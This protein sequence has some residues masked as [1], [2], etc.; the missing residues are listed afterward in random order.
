MLLS[1]L[2]Q[3]DAAKSPSEVVAVA[4]DYLAS[5]TPEELARLPVQCR[6]GRV[7]D[8]QDIDQLLHVNLV[9]EYGRNRLSGE[10]LAALQRLT[11]FIVRA[12][13]RIAQIRGKEEVPPGQDEE[14]PS[15]KRS[16]AEREH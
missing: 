14:P 16:A 10:A 15:G 11:S 13:V 2:Q 6:P 4:R 12:S 9:E 5:W 7:K 8:D 3:I 1:W